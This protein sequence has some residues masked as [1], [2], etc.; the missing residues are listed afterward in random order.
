MVFKPHSREAAEKIIDSFFWKATHSRI[1]IFKELGHK[2]KRHKTN[3]LNTIEQGV[4]QCLS[5]ARVES[6]NNKIKISIR[7]A[8][9]FRNYENMVDMIML[10]CSKLSI[11]LPNRGV[12]GMKVM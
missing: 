5:N 3:I 8:Y 9:G 7:K 6:I 11:P 4:K 12:L 2:I 1:Q 10:V